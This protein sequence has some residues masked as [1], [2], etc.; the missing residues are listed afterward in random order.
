M[1]LTA[2]DYY[3]EAVVGESHEIR[4]GA[5]LQFH[6]RDPFDTGDLYQMRTTEE[7]IKINNVEGNAIIISASGMG[8][9]GRVVHHLEQLLPDPKNTIML[10]G[11]QAAG[12]RGRALEEGQPQLKMYGKWIPVN[13]KVIKVESFSVHADASELVTWL[14]PI[15]KPQ[16][17]FVVHGEP[18]G[19]RG[20][21]Q[22]L[23]DQL[24][25]NVTIPKAGQVFTIN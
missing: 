12:T 22:R 20:L 15:N 19:Q 8:T 14:A 2:L 7:S 21:A 9:G 17:A 18:E 4:D 13:A 1:A 10:V 23:E 24:H 6:D 3:R 11:F 5:H 25:W 16:Q